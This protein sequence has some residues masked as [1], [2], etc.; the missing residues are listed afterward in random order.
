MTE[1]PRMVK[2][3]LVLLVDDQ[4]SNLAIL[5]R[6]VEG[7]GYRTCE[8]EN[9][10]VAMEILERLQPDAVLLDI[11]MPVLDGFGV[12]HAIRRHSTLSYTPVIIIT[13]AT[14]LAIRQQAYNE[15]ADDFLLKPIDAATLRARLRVA[16]RLKQV[17]SHMEKERARLAFIANISRELTHINSLQAMLK[18]MVQVCSDALHAEYGN[19]ILLDGSSDVTEVLTNEQR[20]INLQHIQRVL[21]Q[22]AAGYVLRNRESLR[23]D[24]ITS[25]PH[26]L[27]IP[28]SEIQ[29]GSALLIPI[30][31]AEGPLGILSIHH[32]HMWY[33]SADDQALLEL[34]AYQVA[35]VIRQ[36]RLREEQEKLTDQLSLQTR[37]LQL[38]NT[39]A[40]SLTSNLDLSTLYEVIDQ[41][42]QQLMGQI[43]IGWYVLGEQ[44]SVLA[45][46]STYGNNGNPVVDQPTHEALIQLGELD[47]AVNF[48]LSD[49]PQISV[50]AALLADG[51]EGGIGI[52]L[53]H[54]GQLLGVLVIGAYGRQFTPEEVS[55]LEMARPHLVV[56][57]TNAQAVADQAARHME[58]AEL[59][60]LRNMAEL[61]GHMAHH[62]NNLFAAILG[63]TQLA[64]LDAVNAEQQ[65]LLATVVEQVRDGAA[66]IRRLHL[67]KG[68][69]RVAPPFTLE[70][71][72]TL[73][74]LLEHVA[75]HRSLPMV[76]T[77]I[78]PNLQIAVHERELL[79]LCSEL[80]GNAYES[81]SDPDAI[82]LQ[83]RALPNHVSISI[84][85]RGNGVPAQRW[86]D[87]WRP[88]VTTRGP[89]R[90]G[91][92]LPICSAVMWRIGGT[93]TLTANVDGPGVTATL[94]FPNFSGGQ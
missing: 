12:L 83:A 29:T 59:R 36:A 6:L 69:D 18:H 79:T 23:I 78:E 5:K 64:E 54:Q 28:T 89:Q 63:N 14:E 86:S 57:L 1:N 40:Q 27:H 11:F 41:Q 84:T 75:Q 19:L 3:P 62:F 31:D 58:Q 20:Y 82:K 51:Y 46:S 33:F 4:R 60:H 50:V 71:E 65:A 43:V 81:G 90:L 74:A 47:Q 21:T 9:G 2:A 10:A 61:A 8:A 91:L 34:V 26:W 30:D 68:G 77:S 24:D 67:L 22:G 38:V 25:D 55:L 44:S 76:H 88:F 93:I 72:E 13:A 7:T 66:M 73:P 80:L 42:M 53:H 37:Q 48:S 17:L 45:Y 85:D 56:A 15:G 92:G 39:L 87:I 49:A 16:I 32:P 70:L 94:L 52:P 35:G